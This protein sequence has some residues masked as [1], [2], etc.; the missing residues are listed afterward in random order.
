VRQLDGIQLRHWGLPSGEGR[1]DEALEAT[2]DALQTFNEFFGPYPY[3]EL[4]VVAVPLRLASGV[5]YPGL[6]M[7]DDTLYGANANNSTLLGVVVAHEAAHQ[8]WYGVVGNNVLQQPWQDE[9]LASFSQLLY[10]EEH[11]PNWYAGT[12]QAY[13]TRVAAV[14]ERSEETAVGQPVEAFRN[15]SGDYGPVVYTKGALFFIALR[16]RLG[17]EAFFNA[18]Q[19]YYAQNQFGLAQPNDLL[20]AFEASCG[21]DLDSFYQQWGVKE[22]E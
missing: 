9:A 6:F 15:R 13:A 7:I 10:L 5:E 3:A 1:W 16:E 19:S 4:D 8:W 14:E 11:Q 2:A 22:P 17:D 20:S 18:L 12:L 21:C